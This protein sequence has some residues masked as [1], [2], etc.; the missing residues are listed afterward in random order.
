[1]DMDQDAVQVRP[2]TQITGEPEFNE[3]FIEDAG[4][5]EKTVVGGVGNGWGVAITTLMHERAGLAF[6]LQVQL[7]IA[8]AQLGDLIRAEGSPAI[9]SSVRRF[10]SS[11]SRPR[12]AAQRLARL[13]AIMKTRRA[14][15]RGVA[16]QV[17]MVRL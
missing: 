11:T 5:D 15:A 3:L 17:A 1:M 10:A 4:S 2:L 16:S 8:L 7:K 13:T 6:G 12:P 9:P 14:G